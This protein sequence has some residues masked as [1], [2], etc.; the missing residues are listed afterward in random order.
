MGQELFF[1]E[2]LYYHVA[3]IF[4][5]YNFHYQ[6]GKRLMK[7]IET[8]FSEDG[9]LL[10]LLDG[11][12]PFRQPSAAGHLRLRSWAIHDNILGEP[13]S[14]VTMYKYID[15]QPTPCGEFTIPW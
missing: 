2:P 10:P 5:V 15:P 3:K 14:N 13:F 4:E 1:V 6:S 7:R 11:S 12:S 9:D 8:G